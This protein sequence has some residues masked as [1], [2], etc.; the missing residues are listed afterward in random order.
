VSTI[1]PLVQTDWLDSHLDDPDLRVYD[2]TAFF[3]APEGRMHFDSGAEAYSQGHI[4]G[5]GFMD[6]LSELSDGASPLTLQRLGADAFSRAMSHYGVGDG[7]RVVLYDRQ[8]S[9]WATRVWWMLRAMGFEDAAVLDGGWHKW[10]TEERAVSTA[11]AHIPAATFTPK[12]RPDL[13]VGRDSVLAA[14]GR[15]DTAIVSALTP[16]LHSGEGLDIVERGHIASST[17]VPF[18]EM[19]D[20][21]TMAFLP[22]DALRAKFDAAGASSAKQAITYCGC[23]IAA[24]SDAFALHLAGRDNVA[25]YDGSIEEWS[26]DP[27]LPMER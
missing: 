13:F 22:V 8:M 26:K 14:V 27:N 23:G 7:V 20:P 1:D 2:C 19:V 5:S 16:E 24:T 9:M 4:P 18:T 3:T 15:E 11:P 6:I 12:P 17:C 10:T 21:E 25:V